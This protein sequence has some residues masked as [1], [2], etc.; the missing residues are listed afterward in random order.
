MVDCDS[1]R[2]HIASVKHHNRKSSGSLQFDLDFSGNAIDH[3]DLRKKERPQKQSGASHYK[4][5]NGC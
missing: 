3:R 5:T 4:E 1:R 2:I